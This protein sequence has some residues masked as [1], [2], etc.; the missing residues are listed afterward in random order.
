MS[1]E[2]L[3]ATNPDIFILCVNY[4]D[5]V[6]YIMRTIHYVEGLVDAK[7]VGLVMYPLYRRITVNGLHTSSDTIP[8]KLLKDRCVELSALS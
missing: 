1:Y 4:E 7:L 3:I 2:F 6:S 5:D 8:F